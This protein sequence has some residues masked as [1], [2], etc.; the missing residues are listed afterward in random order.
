MVWYDRIFKKEEFMMLTIPSSGFVP[1]EEFKDL[2]D[3]SKVMYY[4]LE[5]SDG[6][7]KLKFYNKN[8]KLIKPYKETKNGK[9]NEKISKTK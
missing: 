9:S 1:I 2:L 4:S 7:L 3:I 6:I 8:K 5:V